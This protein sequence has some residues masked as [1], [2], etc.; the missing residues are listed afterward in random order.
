MG[1][2]NFPKKVPGEQKLLKKKSC[3][4]SHGK[5]LSK[6]FLL[7]LVRFLFF[8]NIMV[9]L[10]SEKNDVTRF[11]SA[12]WLILLRHFGGRAKNAVQIT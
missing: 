6:R 10:L 11:W 1:F 5:K 12:D 3:K 9:R 2:G 4:D 7:S 8:K